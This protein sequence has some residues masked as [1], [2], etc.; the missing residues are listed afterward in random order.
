MAKK[1]GVLFL[2]AA[3]GP[4]NYAGQCIMQRRVKEGI[5][6]LAIES[7]MGGVE[8]GIESVAHAAGLPVSYVSNL[9][10]MNE[11]QQV[12]ARIAENQRAAVEQW[13]VHTGHVGGL[14]DGVA[15]LTI[16]NRPPDASLCLLRVSKKMQLDKALATPLRQLSEDLVTWQELIASC[17]TFIDDGRSLAS[18]Y[19]QRRLV[20]IGF[21]FAGA[22]A[23]A[24]VVVWA[25]RVSLARSRIDELLSEEDPCTAA[26]A[27]PSD[28]GKASDEQR[29]TIEERRAAC[30]EAA[31]ARRRAEEKKREE[32]AKQK[33][34][35]AKKAARA[36]QC[37]ALIAS[38][39]AG[40]PNVGALE[41]A[42]PHAA[43][44]ERIAKKKLQP[45][46][47][48]SLETLPCLDSEDAV[49]LAEV[50]LEGVLATAAIWMYTV[51]PSKL[52]ADL[53]VKG[54]GGVR[55]RQLTIFE[56]HVEEMARRAVRTGEEE[57]LARILKDCD[58]KDRLELK[59][60]QYCNAARAIVA[61][62]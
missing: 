39:V 40:S 27:E 18:A 53:M 10:P 62:K 4:L 11:L 45:A 9:L 37:K 7:L 17:K 43:L 51:A 54:K 2:N 26:S 24:V 50:Y 41:E 21:A 33:A 49:E 25:V 34:A 6:E 13:E 47:I 12:A 42:K 31:A 8:R 58:V 28:L 52:A 44:L 55:P 32:L 15:D 16:D 56:Q 3:M 1:L 35:A 19:R 14:L 46:D 59:R 61:K 48:G 20:R 30:E 60:G 29:D 22:L 23:I 57:A 5:N 38:V 36:G